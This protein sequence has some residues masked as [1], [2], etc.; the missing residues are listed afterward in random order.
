MIASFKRSVI[1]S[2]SK[3]SLPQWDLRKDE[4]HKDET[5]AVAEYKQHAFNKKIKNTCQPSKSS[6]RTTIPHP[7]RRTTPNVL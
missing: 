1:T 4:S 6:A 2:I 3:H 5:R 7:Y